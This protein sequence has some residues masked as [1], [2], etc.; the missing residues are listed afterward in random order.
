MDNELSRKI[1]ELRLERGMTLEDV[2]KIVGVGKSTV[3]KWET[4]MIANMGRDKIALLAQ[5]L[6]VTP[7]YLMGWKEDNKTLT[8]PN[9]PGLT[10]GEKMMLELF[11]QIPPNK[12]EVVLEM[13]RLA[14]KTQ[15]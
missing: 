11:R 12:Q 4:G 15:S 7:S 8:S 9:A 6:G 2:A 5:A 1:K 13:I 3:R 10:D 14:L